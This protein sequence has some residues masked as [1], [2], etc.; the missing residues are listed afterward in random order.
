MAANADRLQDV[1]RDLVLDH[2]KEP[3]CF[4]A[5]GEATHRADGIN[6]VC[7]DKLHIELRLDGDII[8][9]VGFTGAGCAIT[10]ASASLMSEALTG[11][12]VRGAVNRSA[13]L[14]RALDSGDTD[15]ELGD[16]SALLGVRKHPSRVKC[17]TLAWV[18]MEQAID[19]SETTVTT[20]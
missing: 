5:V 13:A 10:M 1:Y 16:L 7:G 18:A 19:G 4:G 17:A 9:E 2:A 12:D 3:R 20:E 15:I 6:V 14:Q 11:L 8:R